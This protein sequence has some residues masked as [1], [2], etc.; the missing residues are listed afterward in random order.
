MFSEEQA[1]RRNGSLGLTA[2]HK[3][4]DKRNVLCARILADPQ[5]AA[6]KKSAQ[7]WGK[8]ESAMVSRVE[9]LHCQR[10]STHN[11]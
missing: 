6:P 10:I 2:A 8:A 9:T 11:R 3:K 4:S 7:L 1:D 5:Q